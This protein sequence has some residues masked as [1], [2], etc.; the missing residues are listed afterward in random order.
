MKR[1]LLALALLSSLPLAM[2][3]MAAA[4]Q[5]QD[6]DHGWGHQDDHDHDHGDHGR[7]HDDHGWRDDD[8]HDH[9][10]HVGW[11]KH[12]RR[13]EYLPERYR[14]REYYVDD[15]ARYHLYAPPRGYV[16]VQGDSGQFVLIA[17]ATG[18]IVQEMLGQ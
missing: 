11:D 2:T 10:R 16:W 17:V 14:V 1:Y 4:A 12:Y 7:G 18:L 6:H 15:Y 5:D 9:G 8:H 3:S 13:G